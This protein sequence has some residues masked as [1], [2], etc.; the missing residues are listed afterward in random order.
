[1]AHIS[2]S[3]STNTGWH[4]FQPA[5][6]AFGRLTGKSRLD[7]FVS[8]IEQKTEKYAS[9]ENAW[10]QWTNC[11]EAE[12]AGCGCNYHLWLGAVDEYVHLIEADWARISPSHRDPGAIPQSNQ[13]A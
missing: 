12:E 4:T 1:M 9:L 8:E 5:A 6:T 3:A 2:A 10:L 7:P 11:R 13:A